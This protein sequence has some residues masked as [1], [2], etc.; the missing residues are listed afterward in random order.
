MEMIVPADP[1]NNTKETPQTFK[2]YI[3]HLPGIC[4]LCFGC[5]HYSKEIWIILFPIVKMN[6][7]QVED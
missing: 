5:A 4:L 6:M 7:N 1:V 3:E 2:P